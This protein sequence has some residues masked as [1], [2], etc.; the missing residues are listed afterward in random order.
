MDTVQIIYWF[1][2]LTMDN[3]F[4]PVSEK[5]SLSL[6]LVV[7]MLILDMFIY[8]LIVLYVEAIFPGEYGLPRVWYFPCTP[9]FWCR[10]LAG[11]YL[12]EIERH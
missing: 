11:K 10:N 9:R 2:D 4:D 5:E 7:M 3:I 8:M 6:G 1:T 12:F